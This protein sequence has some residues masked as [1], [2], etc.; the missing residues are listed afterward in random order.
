MEIQEVNIN[1][2]PVDDLSVLKR[3]EGFILRVPVRDKD[4]SVKKFLDIPASRSQLLIL[5]DSVER[6][7]DRK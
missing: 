4:G 6:A 7:L 5:A 1:L 2:H 3:G